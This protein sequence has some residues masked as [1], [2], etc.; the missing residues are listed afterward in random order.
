MELSSCCSLCY[1]IWWQWEA[2]KC[3]RLFHLVKFTMKSLCSRYPPLSLFTCWWKINEL[4]ICI[5]SLLVF[6]RRLLILCPVYCVLVN[7]NPRCLLIME[8]E[9]TSFFN[10]PVVFSHN[11]LLSGNIMVNDEEGI[12]LCTLLSYCRFLQ[13]TL[14]SI[15]VSKS[16]FWFCCFEFFFFFSI[17]QKFDKEVLYDGCLFCLLQHNIDCAGLFY[18]CLA[19]VYPVECRIQSS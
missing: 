14:P 7:F 10:A 11:D 1:W 17:E 9:L 5:K 16:H 13:V 19:C 6:T 8:Q 4:H 15:V 3:T 18:T 2:E 12:P